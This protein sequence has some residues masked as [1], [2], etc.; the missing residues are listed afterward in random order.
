MSTEIK[1]FAFD[2]DGT[3]LDNTGK[4]TPYAQQMLAQAAK[5]GIV[6]VAATG[7]ALDFVPAEVLALPN[8]QYAITSNGAVVHH[9]PTNT[10]LQ[11]LQ[12]PPE[13]VH[14]LVEVMEQ[15]GIVAEVF[16]SGRAYGQRDYVEHPENYNM[17]AHSLHYLRTTRRPVTDIYRFAR[18]HANRMDSM[19]FIV[20]Q[21]DQSRRLRAQITAQYPQLHI[22]SSGIRRVEI[23][24]G[25]AGKG[26]A[27]ATVL[28]QLGI[29]PT[30]VAAFGDADNDVEMLAL[31]EVRVAMADA[32]E[33]SKEIA[34][35]ITDSNE[36]DGF[37]KAIAQILQV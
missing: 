20:P 21:D 17:A 27:L 1:C 23:A 22:T 13:I 14:Q 26:K 34:T 35:Y 28:S 8:L 33:N 6:L 29:A 3:A 16:V 9:V 15:E 12:I 31:A 19:D 30:Q 11:R 36:N 4:L 25:Q 32:S 24:H 2:L 18:A 37:A 7:R 5:Q 10:C